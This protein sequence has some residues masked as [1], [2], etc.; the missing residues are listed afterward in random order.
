MGCSNFYRK[1]KDDKDAKGDNKEYDIVEPPEPYDDPVVPT[2]GGEFSSDNIKDGPVKRTFNCE[3]KICKNDQ[4]SKEGSIVGQVQE[5]TTVPEIDFSEVL[6]STAHR[7]KR[8]QLVSSN[9]LEVHHR[10]DQM[11]RRYSGCEKSE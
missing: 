4:K 10:H 3:K 11:Q 6:Q 9:F 7:R 5:Q 1:G 8:V 2:M